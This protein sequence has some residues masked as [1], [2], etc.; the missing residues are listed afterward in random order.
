MEVKDSTIRQGNSICK[1]PKAGG[2][3]SPI[4]EKQLVFTNHQENLPKGLNFWCSL[5][6]SSSWI[7][8]FRNIY[9]NKE[10]IVHLG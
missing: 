1:A 5:N 4:L 7:Q 9:K 10:S 6:I 8:N 2:E 3:H